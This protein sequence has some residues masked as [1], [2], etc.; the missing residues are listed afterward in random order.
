MRISTTHLESFRLYRDQ[1]WMTFDKLVSDLTTYTDPI[2]PMMVGLDFHSALEGLPPRYGYRMTNM[3]AATSLVPPGATPE[4][5]T[6]ISI[7][8]H[9]VVAK[10]DAIL[11]KTVYETKTKL[12]TIEAARY[13]ESYQWRI[14]AE[15]FDCDAVVYILASLKKVGEHDCYVQRVD[16]MTEYRY[17][18]M[19]ADIERLVVA[20]EGLVMDTPALRTKFVDNPRTIPPEVR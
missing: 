7:A 3:V 14:Y 19:R 2:E 8:G 6:I 20:F 10:A 4:L 9:D 15:A 12:G 1:D 5:R 16:P 18:G 11:G 13:S 17:P